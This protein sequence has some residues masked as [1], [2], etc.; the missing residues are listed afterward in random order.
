MASMVYQCGSRCAGKHWGFT[1]KLVFTYQP[2]GWQELEEFPLYVYLIGHVTVTTFSWWYNFSLYKSHINTRHLTSIPR[3][4]VKQ[5]SWKMKCFAL[6]YR[7]C[8]SL[9]VARYQSKVWTEK[10]HNENHTV[11]WTT[12]RLDIP[13]WIPAHILP[14]FELEQCGCYP[15]LPSICYLGTKLLLSLLPSRKPEWN[16]MQKLVQFVSA[17]WRVV[18][19]SAPLCHYKQKPRAN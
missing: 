3:R 10:E 5:D 7:V 15:C 17:A 19:S 13:Y 12:S 1:V 8:P 6:S 4:Q 18:R 14:S 16:G 2:A 9:P 11:P